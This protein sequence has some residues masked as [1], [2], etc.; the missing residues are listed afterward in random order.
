[1]PGLVFDYADPDAQA[2]PVSP[3]EPAE[4]DFAAF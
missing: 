4:F 2:M 3:V 1:M